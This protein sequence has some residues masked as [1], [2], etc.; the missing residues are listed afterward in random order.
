LIK[1]NKQL[2]NNVCTQVE[3]L[4]DEEIK[5]INSISYQN[6]I[7][8]RI[9][10]MNG[11]L[12]ESISKCA[13]NLVGKYYSKVFNIKFQ[14]R[15]GDE[16]KIKCN[17]EN[18]NCIEM[19]VDRHQYINGNLVHI[20]ECK[21]YLDRCYMIRASDDCRMIKKY[22]NNNNISSSILAIENS[23]KQ[24]SYDFIMDEGYIDDVFFLTDGK[25]NSSKPIWRKEHFKPLNKN[26]LEYYIKNII[27]MFEGW[28]KNIAVFE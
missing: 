23:V 26:K 5:K 24:E 10:S 8:G 27:N 11:K 21:A 16:L 20:E 15:K 28:R 6:N 2:L 22:Y 9:R 14:S 1:T 25:R 13:W 17:N 18:G 3:N 19:Q 7:G 12:G 4:Y